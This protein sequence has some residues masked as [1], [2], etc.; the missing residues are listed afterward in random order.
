MF[1]HETF[2][3][4]FRIYKL[5]SVMLSS[6]AMH[7]NTGPSTVNITKLLVLCN[8]HTTIRH[9]WCTEPARALCTAAQIQLGEGGGDIAS[10]L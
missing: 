2:V 9:D 3:D 10:A 6:F 5:H 1:Y 7:E 4:S 8:V